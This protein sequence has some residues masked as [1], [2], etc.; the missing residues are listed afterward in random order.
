MYHPTVTA[1]G[2]YP[3]DNMQDE[4]NDWND[5]LRWV[6]LCLHIALTCKVSVL[7]TVSPDSSAT[8]LLCQKT[9]CMIILYVVCSSLYEHHALDLFQGL[10]KF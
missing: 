7:A 8:S 5:A 9:T 4:I 10:V 1:W 2:Q 6:A 3:T